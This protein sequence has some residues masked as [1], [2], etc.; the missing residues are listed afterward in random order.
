MA[1]VNN[2]SAFDKLV[3]GLN[4]QDRA[5]ML[6]R[7]NSVGPKS[8]QLV[9]TEDMQPER[10]L[11]LHLRYKSESCLYK[12]ILWIRSIFQQKSPERLYNEDVIND[13]ARKVNKEHPG[14][15]NLR[16]KV[17]DEGFYDRLLD[18]KDASDFFKPYFNFIDETKGDFYVFLSTFVAPEL[19]DKINSQADPFT[20]EFTTEPGPDQKSKLLKALDNILSDIDGVTKSNLYAAVSSVNW[21]KKFS[22]L[23]FLHFTAQFTNLADD[24]Y[25]CP[26]RNA[27]LDFEPFSAV[28]TNVH[29]IQNE[30]LEAIYLYVQRKDLKSTAS[31][32]DIERGVKEFMAKAVSKL[33]AIQIFISTIPV[34]KIGKIINDDYDWQPKNM[35]GVE[36]WFPMF[37]SQWRSIIE[38]RWNDWIR[39]CKKSKIIKNLYSDF[40]LDEFPK[41]KYQPW[42]QLWMKVPFNFQLSGGFLSWFATEKY[43]VVIS[44]LNDVLLE[45]IFNG[46]QIRSEYADAMNNFVQANKEIQELLD[47]LSPTGEYGMLFAEFSTTAVRS[48]QIQNQIHSMMSSTEATIR[49]AIKKF[50]KS[51][52][53]LSRIIGKLFNTEKKTQREILQN[54]LTIKGR[55]N[56]EWRDSLS[57]ARNI[58]MKSIYYVSELEPI[59][60]ETKEL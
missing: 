14:V 21:L 57:E 20:L 32:Q 41:I 19:A 42:T 4:S 51:T 59:D 2:R 24:T 30:V 53:V 55:Q 17:L 46:V 28:F 50:L 47:R 38:I 26:Y 52:E 49:S 1:L 31:Q 56:R 44:S 8:V 39:E 3:A 12:F 15:L 45:G 37:R 7:L 10:N 58:L 22:V 40:C 33:S 11:S 25:T 9:E 27:T 36:A 13:L 43:G 5:D 34:I 16:A 48:T 18:I 29:S 23:P 54:F 6:G 35:E 60:V